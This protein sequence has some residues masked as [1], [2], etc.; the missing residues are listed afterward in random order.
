MRLI[1]PALVLALMAC[2]TFTPGHGVTEELANRWG[3]DY[4]HVT[5]LAAEVKDGLPPGNE[6]IPQTGWSVCELMAHNGAPT[7]IDYQEL[8]GQRFSTWWYQAETEAHMVNL[9]LTA[10]RGWRVSYV[11][12]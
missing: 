12:W 6:Y 5:S 9:E 4:S 3:C 8:R 7:R 1:L 10:S 11:G 2:A